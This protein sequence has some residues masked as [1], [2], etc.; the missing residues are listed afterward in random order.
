MIPLWNGPITSNKYV[1]SQGD[2]KSV[3]V[4]DVLFCGGA[5]AMRREVVDL[6]NIKYVGYDQPVLVLEFEFSTGTFI[7]P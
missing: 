2:Q 1:V 5:F 6:S 4:C 7:D 3:V